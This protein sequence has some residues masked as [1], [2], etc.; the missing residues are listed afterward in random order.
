MSLTDSGGCFRERRASV[1]F[2]WYP[3]P[4]RPLPPP[5]P[6]PP[7][8]V[9]HHARV[10]RHSHGTVRQSETCRKSAVTVRAA[11]IWGG[12]VVSAEHI[13]ATV[14]AVVHLWG[15]RRVRYNTSFSVIQP[16]CCSVSCEDLLEMLS[17]SVCLVVSFCF[18]W[19]PLCVF[20]R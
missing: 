3:L 8:V 14:W 16:H 4:W 10:S 6:P 12:E 13:T 2:F 18:T 20:V 1:L 11:D 17:V 5:S 9:N 7:D 19:V 15:H